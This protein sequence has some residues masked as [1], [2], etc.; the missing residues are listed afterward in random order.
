MDLSEGSHPYSCLSL[1]K[2]LLKYKATNPTSSSSSSS[3]PS[4]DLADID[5]SSQSESGQLE[6]PNEEEEKDLTLTIPESMLTWRGDHSSP[7]TR[8]LVFRVTSCVKRPS[9]A[10]SKPKRKP[11]QLI[12]FVSRKGCRKNVAVEV[13][14]LNL[15]DIEQA[16]AKS[17]GQPDLGP[18]SG[19]GGKGSDVRNGWSEMNGVD[20]CNGT[21]DLESECVAG[22]ENGGVGRLVS[23][24][25]N[26]G[27]ADSRDGTGT[28][29]RG[30]TGGVVSSELLISDDVSMNT[31]TDTCEGRGNK[32]TLS[33]HGPL[34]K[35]SKSKL[36]KK[37][38]SDASVMTEISLGTGIIKDMRS[39]SP[40]S[41]SPTHD[42]AA[43]SFASPPPQNDHAP[44]ANNHAHSSLPPLPK[45]GYVNKSTSPRMLFRNGSFNGVMN[46]YALPE[47][48]A[49]L[50]ARSLQQSDSKNHVESKVPEKEVTEKTDDAVS[51]E[52]TDR[53][54]KVN[55]VTPK[56][57]LKQIVAT[58]KRKR[59][60]LAKNSSAKK[61]KRVLRQP[62]GTGKRGT[63]SF[64]VSLPRVH[65]DDHFGSESGRV[66]TRTGAKRGAHDSTPPPPPPS[67]ITA[68]EGGARGGVGGGSGG[69]G[70]GKTISTSSGNAATTTTYRRRSEIQLLLDGD[71]PRGQRL[72]ETDIPVFVAEDISNRSTCNSASSNLIWLESSTRK[73]T[74]VEHF[75]YPI[76]SLSP[77]R[78]APGA[79]GE[80]HSAGSSPTM[81]HLPG[82]GTGVGGGGGNH[83]KRVSNNTE[84]VISPPTKH[85]RVTSTH[86]N[87]ADTSRR[88][89]K[90]R[91]NVR[92]AEEAVTEEGAM[93]IKEEEEGGRNDQALD[94]ST[95]AV[96]AP[97][98]QSLA[99][100]P[101]AAQKLV[102]TAV[103]RDTPPTMV[104]TTMTYSGELAMFDSRGECLVKD[105]QYSILMQSCSSSSSFAD[106]SSTGGK[107]GP[108]QGLSTFEPLTWATVFGGGEV[109]AEMK[110]VL[111][112]HA[113]TK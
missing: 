14:R 20:A 86:S 66:G 46:G 111:E 99:S 49:A 87:P 25:S 85:L 5:T 83:R 68:S 104:T 26:S 71:K 80:V 78:R 70:G 55:R 64:L 54:V 24:N 6:E 92:R 4:E 13:N 42:H 2:Q 89:E 27:E 100:L 81:L 32:G 79:S 101:S 103:E 12:N 77:T 37:A 73:I 16:K 82:G 97:P 47:V 10:A 52:K 95:Q 106:S 58:L 62:V 53:V 107:P 8:M 102:A 69:G 11:V 30:R 38:R 23:S 28:R 43:S 1:G 29:I 88:K 22:L 98:T 65:Y 76:P 34:T 61:F 51:K 57:P 74:P 50:K 19:E 108:Q 18:G 67:R 112:G 48:A 75:A 59:K 39:V 36:N 113:C 45:K 15:A 56:K 60:R 91:S 94:A 110:L 63:R 17:K 35:K 109:S 41:G 90:E 93:E 7:G 84:L 3:N 31:P 9:S 40:L 105:G 96:A 44:L 21:G 33:K 72:S